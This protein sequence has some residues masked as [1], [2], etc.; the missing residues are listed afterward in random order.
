MMNM[1]LPFK[2]GLLLGTAGIVV[3]GDLLLHLAS[4]SY[5]GRITVIAHLICILAL[6]GAGYFFSRLTGVLGRATEVCK[7]AA[8]GNLEARITEVPQPG[9][10][11]TLQTNINN[12]LDNTDAFVREAS[13]SMHYI[14]Q[15][16]YFRKVLLRGLPGSFRGAAQNINAASSVMEARMRDFGKF[17]DGLES[18]VGAVV[19]ALS[20]AA[21]QMHA[22]A[23]TLSR[24]AVET[25]ERAATAASATEQASGNVQMVAAAAEQLSGSLAE[26][27]RQ[28][29]LSSRIAHQ[30]VEEAG[31]TNVSVASLSQ[32]VNE[33]G[34]VVRLISDIAGQTNLL[35]LNATIEAARAG[36]AGKGF[37]VVASEVKQLAGETARA[38]T[39]ISDQITAIQA[40]TGSAVETIRA[41]GETISDMNDIARS[42]TTAIEQQ[43]AA[44]REIAQNIQQAANGTRKVSGDISHVKQA[45]D[46]T[47]VT[48][49]EVLNAASL[50]SEQAEHLRSE[51]N[52][53]L[54]RARA[55]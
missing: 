51:V 36:E 28:V 54:T 16:K 45:A 33:I 6:I 34:D 7:A 8:K 47:G 31:R 9:L 55:I 12:L 13:G 32:F 41:I 2:S 25:S 4:P 52:L 11:G 50:L 49:H 1:S 14:S 35:A 17:A 3:T 40:A 48:S 30:A 44:T 53:F 39:Q 21:E 10:V 27:S 22:N 18:N 38:T 29:A 37:A 23:G 26:V 46:N 42:V 43:E 15:G 19:G 24:D 20:S 5:H